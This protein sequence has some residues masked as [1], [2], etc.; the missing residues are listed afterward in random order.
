MAIPSFG[1]MMFELLTIFQAPVLYCML[2]ERAW[3]KANARPLP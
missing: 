2:K 3:N 1:G